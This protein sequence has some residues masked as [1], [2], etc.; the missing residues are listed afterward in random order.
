MSSPSEAERIEAAL[1]EA[2][3]LVEEGDTPLV[4]ADWAAERYELEHRRE[5]LE[6]RVQEATDDG[7]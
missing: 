4:A 6:E 5:E 3:D 2:V 7:E 1:D